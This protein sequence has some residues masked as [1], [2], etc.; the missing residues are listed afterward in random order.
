MKYDRNIIAWSNDQLEGHERQQKISSQRAVVVG[1]GYIAQNVL[2]GLAGLGVENIL[3][4]D[5]ERFDTDDLDFLVDGQNLGDRKVDHFASYIRDL[6]DEIKV[7]S[8]FSRISVPII[9][10]Y[11][12]TII[13]ECTNSLESKLK[14]MRTGFPV[15]SGYSNSHVAMVESQIER[16]GTRGF[17]DREQRGFT[18]SIAAG[19]MLEEFRKLQFAYDKFD[20]L[21]EEK[22]V[23]DILA[24][25]RT[26]IT[27]GTVPQFFRGKKALVVGGGGIGTYVALNLSLLGFGH[28]DIVDMDKYEISNVNRQFFARKS[29]GMNKAKAVS[30]AIKRIDPRLDSQHLEVKI[31]R[32]E[33]INDIPWLRKLF[34]ADVRIS[35]AEN[36]DKVRNI[37]EFVDHYYQSVEHEMLDHG[38][39]GKY[40]IIFGCLDNKYARM[41]LSNY[42]ERYKIPYIDGGTTATNGKV[43]LYIPNLTEP[44]HKQIPLENGQRLSMSCADQPNPSVVMA[45]MIIGGTMVGE[46]IKTL[47]HFQDPDIQTISYQIYD[48]KRIKRIGVTNA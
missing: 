23:Y 8:I 16:R 31:G 30:S 35:R 40:D 4:L 25:N 43:R 19:V 29:F 47:Y 3:L 14:A 37:G 28:I 22:F 45:N 33:Y 46:S 27:S 44:I 5:N 9:K 26:Q 39:L 38:L 12:P 48:P 6:N 41:W 32:I 21:L 18:S 11:N 15:I 2:V 42:S 10:D 36:K 34:D 24:K 1:T 7:E 20:S 13:F 17:E